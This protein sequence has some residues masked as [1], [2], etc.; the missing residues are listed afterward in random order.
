MLRLLEVHRGSS[1]PQG[2]ARL[3]QRWLTSVYNTFIYRSTIRPQE[4][5][6]V[7]QEQDTCISVT[8]NE[9]G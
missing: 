9:C 5:V 6:S 2:Q 8:T 3:I 1:D 4:C 7:A